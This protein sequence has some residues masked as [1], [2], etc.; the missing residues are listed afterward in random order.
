MKT[1]VISYLIND[2][3]YIL[4]IVLISWYAIIKIKKIESIR[5]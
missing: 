5:L 2:E 3:L 1:N 4:S